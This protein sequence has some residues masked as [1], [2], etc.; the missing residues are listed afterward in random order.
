MVAEVMVGLKVAEDGMA[1]MKE[2]V[3]AMEGTGE[4]AEM[5]AGNTGVENTAMEVAGEDSM[6]A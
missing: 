1:G 6:E 2:V 5:A 3:L 4:K